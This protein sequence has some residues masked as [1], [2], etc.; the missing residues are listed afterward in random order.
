VQIRTFLLQKDAVIAA[1]TFGAKTVINLS[2]IS[3]L[4]K[5]PRKQ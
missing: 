5:D 4:Q 1:R 3:M 2:N